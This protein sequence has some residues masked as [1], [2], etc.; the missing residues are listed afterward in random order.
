VAQI[1]TE[2]IEDEGFIRVELLY[3]WLYLSKR[4]VEDGK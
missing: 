1:H 4:L 2:L 3:H